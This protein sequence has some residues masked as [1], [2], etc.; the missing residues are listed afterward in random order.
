MNIHSQSR[1]GAVNQFL[2]HSVTAVSARDAVL[3]WLGPREEFVAAYPP[4][5]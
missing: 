1:G 5:S 4:R 2:H 3:G